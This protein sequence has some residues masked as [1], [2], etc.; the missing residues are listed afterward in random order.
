MDSLDSSNQG[1]FKYVFNFDDNTKSELLNIIQFSTLSF[2][3]VVALNKLMQKY[4]PEADD[5]KGSVEILAEIVIQTFVLF[6]GIFFIN[7]L[8][9]FVPPY[10]GVKYPD[11]STVNIVLIGLVILLSLQTKLGEKV[12]ILADRLSE[13]WNG[14][15]EKKGKSNKSQNSGNVK[16]TQPISPQL[17]M[18][19]Q[20]SSQEMAMN[21]S[22]Q[23]GSST[24][25]ITEL[26]NYNTTYVNGNDASSLIGNSS[27]GMESMMNMQSGG[28]N[29]PM[30]ANSVLGGSFG[31]NF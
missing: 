5:Q 11:F 9:S 26:P 3:P 13:L 6:L 21:Q 4:V 16:V 12:G 28:F 23:G 20:P 15:P 7:R 1:F 17:P 10:S 25:S 18:M 2:V 22:F 30:A 31:A 19:Q 14:A 27:P 8:V 29:E 24:T